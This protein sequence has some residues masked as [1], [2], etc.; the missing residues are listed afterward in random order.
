MRRVAVA[1]TAVLVGSFIQAAPASAEDEEYPW[2]PAVAREVLVTYVTEGTPSV[3]RAA[4]EMLLADDAAIRTFLEGGVDEAWA[5]DARAA[6]ESLASMDGPAMRAGALQALAGSPADVQAYVDGGWRAPWAAD[7]RVRAYRL[8]ESG[9]PTMRAAAQKA[10]DGTPEQLT[11]FLA[12]GRDA[13]AVADDRL[14]ATQMLTGGA[15]NSG[16]V[17]DTAAAQALQGSAD[18]LREFIT[19]GQFVARAR[20]KELASIRSLTEQAKQASETTARESLAATEASNRAANAAEEA[21]KQAKIAA[22]ETAAAGG[23]AAKASAAAGRAAD[24]ADGAADAA[25]DAVSASN[26]AMRAARVASDAARKATTAAS[27]TAQAAARAQ[28]AAADARTDAGKAAAARQAAQQA[29]DAARKARELDQVR[30]QRDRALAQAKSASTAAKGASANADAAAAE[31]RKAGAQAGVSEAQA[32]RARDAAAR[33]QA[34]A[35][36]ASRAADRAYALAVAAAKASDEAFEFARRAAAHAE[37]AADAAEA[38]AAAAGDAAKAAA[39]SAKHAA[40]AV[41]AAN[42]AVEAANKA[43]ELERLAREEDDAR[44]AESTE[45]GVLAAQDAQ[46]FEQAKNAAVG[47]VVA[48]NRKLLWD[49]AEEDR[50]DPATRQLLSEATASGATTA[51][52]LDRGRRAAINLLTSGGEHTKASAS[53]ALTGGEVELRSW[54]TDGRRVAVGQDDRARVWHLVDTLPDGNEKTAAQAALAGDDA[55]VQAFLRTRNYA[56]KSTADRL[57]IYKIL[58]TS[59]PTVTAAAERAL[60]GTAAERHEF[61]RS[62]QYS[63]RT[64][65]ERLEV[66]RTMDAGGPQV[67][68]AGQVALAGP[69]SYISYFLTAGRYQAAQRDQEQIAH[70]AAV[71]TLIAEAQRY[72]Q[73][74]VSDAAEANRVA[75]V[76]AGKAAEAKT[77]ADQA[78]ASA[79]KAA[80]YANDANTSAVAAKNSAD[81]AAQSATTAR[82]AANSAQASANQAA[83]SAAT[84]GAAAKRARQDAAGAAQAARDA[85][86]AAKQAGADAAAANQAAREAEQIYNTKLKEWEAAQ[87]NTAPGSAWDGNG[88]ALEQHRTWSCMVQPSQLTAECAKVYVDFADALV[89][90]GKC[91]TAGLNTGPGCEMVDDIK[92]FVKDNPDLILDVVQL[93]LAVCG[94][95]PA[96]GEAC[97]GVDA[98]ISFARGDWVGGVLSGLSA[99]PIAGWVPA[100]INMGRL[101]D[102]FRDA[103][104]VFDELAKKCDNVPNSFTPGT[105][106]LLADGSRKAIERLRVGDEVRSANALVGVSAT[107]RVIETIKGS[108]TKVLA[109]VTIDTDG[110]RGTAT[111]TLTATWNHPFWTTDANAWV[112]AG[113]L[114]QGQSLLTA[115]GRHV[116]V[117]KVETRTERTTVY[118]LNVAD[119]HTYYVFAGNVSVLAHNCGKIDLDHGVAGAHPKDHVGKTDAEITTRADTDPKAKGVAS[120]LNGDTYQQTVDAVVADN[121]DKI[122]KWAAKSQSGAEIEYTKR[123]SYPVGRVAKKGETTPKDAYTVTLVL[124]RIDKGYQGHKG[125]W[126]VKTIK[127]Y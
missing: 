115:D 48:W 46:A 67:K 3:K 56:G 14:A 51:V 94:L 25:R 42:T 127:A 120:T 7:E 8:L 17:L 73:S 96:Y 32:K 71:Q 121:I 23:A 47:D 82:N 85:R 69:P 41:Q 19:A 21:K 59:G 31:A 81:Q 108:G 117:D 83:Q 110:D 26:A 118:N 4:A 100:G 68:A 28:R 49:T 106:V 123:F 66:Y 50:V 74:A 124:K 37:A 1:T 84:A 104:R 70:V 36:A 125:A 13:A 29:R 35:A 16:P 76:A 86:Q 72:A 111:E 97:D 60:A 58:E 102:K 9:G 88:T 5:A 101:G 54:L 80:E 20:D 79:D 105:K 93:V 126:V 6:A 95:V 98:G 75:A 22:D 116:E 12:E 90:P 122:N 114:R 39:E 52:M 10:L 64:S 78:K 92:E 61:L 27:L 112:K 44:L 30:A 109:K 11:E 2:D 55:A 24:A 45:Q 62:G 18:D 107:G 53:E 113:E 87:R 40:A 103:W 119:L 77:Y 91:T 33:A 15:N 65:D 43:V 63:A 57:A 34:Q 89:R 99:I 38:A